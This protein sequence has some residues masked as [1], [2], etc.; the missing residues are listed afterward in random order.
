[1]IVLLHQRWVALAEVL[2]GFIIVWLH[3]Q[4]FWI[5]LVSLSWLCCHYRHSSLGV[6]G[7]LKRRFGS[8][9]TVRGTWKQRVETFW[10]SS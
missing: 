3:W 7:A 2:E 9:W 6:W 5:A 4:Q 8:L 10:Q 1:M